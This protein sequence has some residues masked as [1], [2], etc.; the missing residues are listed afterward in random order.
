MVRNG[1]MLPSTRQGHTR[2]VR[3]GRSQVRGEPIV[4]YLRVNRGFAIGKAGACFDNSLHPLGVQSSGLDSRA[5]G[6]F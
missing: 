1:E 3:F 5:P 2:S 4:R 6:Q